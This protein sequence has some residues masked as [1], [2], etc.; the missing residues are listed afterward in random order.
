MVETKL[1]NAHTPNIVKR[2]QSF[3]AFPYVLTLTILVI[4]LVFAP[5]FTILSHSKNVSAKA[6]VHNLRKGEG[7]LITREGAVP[8]QRWRI[9]QWNHS[10]AYFWTVGAYDFRKS[11]SVDL[12]FYF[13]GMHSKDYY[14]D[15]KAELKKLAEKRK[16]KPFLFVA[17]VDTPYSKGRD[18]GKYRWKK[19]APKRGE[20]PDKLIKI[21]N[22]IYRAFTKRFPHI[23]PQNTKI[24]LAGFSGGGRVVSSVGQW[25]AE[26]PDTDKFAKVFRQRLSKIVYFDCWFDPRDL[27]AV[28]TL[29]KINPRIK[30]VGTVAIKR[31][32]KNARILAKKFK[33]RRYGRKKGMVGAG[34]RLVIYRENGHWEAMIKRLEQALNV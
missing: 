18:R 23:K 11:D 5:P 24:V 22:R 17:L 9:P 7:L 3:R 26:T 10:K 31:P 20:R 21:I 32:L 1:V 16:N 14:K 15:F 30:I 2:G 6:K 13:H 27:E 34:G 19:I 33:M 8:Y 28:P 29:L 12:I 25:L 4:A